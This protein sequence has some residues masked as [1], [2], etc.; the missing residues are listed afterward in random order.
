MKYLVIDGNIL[1]GFDFY[2]PFDSANEAH[3][4]MQHADREY[5]ISELLPGDEEY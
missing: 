1:T 4:F 5:V 3:M 2:G